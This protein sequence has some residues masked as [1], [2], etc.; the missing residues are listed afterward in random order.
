MSHRPSGGGMALFRDYRHFAGWRLPLALAMMLAGSLAEGFGIL[1]IVP[2]VALA[3]DGSQLPDQLQPLVS[4][5][6]GLTSDHR[7]LVAVA[8][9]VG[10]M[11]LRA[12]L[13]YRRDVLLARL[14]A[15][16]E[17]S[18]QVRAAAALA[19]RGWPFAAKIGQAGM[20]SLLLTDINRAALAVTM[21]QQ[22]AIALAMLLVQFALAYYLS[23]GMALVAGA[24]IVVGYAAS[25]RWVRKGDRSG[26]VLSA[27][28]DESTAA[29]FRI[30]AGL[31]AALAQGTVPQFLREYR[32]S[33]SRLVSTWAVIT[34][35]SS[36]LRALSGVASALAASLLLV[37]GVRLFELPLAVLLPLLVLFARMS[38]PALSL[39]HSVQTAAVAASAFGAVQQRI[40]ELP[41]D[42][43]IRPRERRPLDWRQ[44]EI[45]GAAFEYSAGT[46]L[47]HA[48]LSVGRGE[49]VGIGGG[50]GAGKTTLLD[51]VAGLIVPQTGHIRVDR[52]P[53]EGEMLERWRDQLAYVGQGDM[54]FD[55]SV[56]DNLLADGVAAD[57]AQLWAALETVGL[58]RRIRALAEGLDQRVGDRGSSLSGG[59]R[60][61]LTLARAL[62]RRPALLILD[63]ATSALD[64]D[65]E[66]DILDRIRAIDPR[67]A[68]LVVAHRRRTLACCDRQIKIVD[69]RLHGT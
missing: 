32:D 25:W 47:A 23:P 33:L 53:L 30:H 24:T 21:A 57:D 63:E 22:A 62:L 44:L 9:F 8:L 61:R 14:Q 19:E 43:P 58:A 27:A 31:K 4:L 39:Q 49:W 15:E 67:P 1:M 16:H 68:A 40:G 56:R 50:S 65:S 11:S 60:Q 20:Q 46:G 51:L 3:M 55:D 45:D 17:A 2:V 36:M 35:D 28:Y 42:L 64:P 10:A 5:T 29:G 54:V 12:L 52:Q 41:Q 6:A 34:S 38:A 48:S 18:M 59:E 66:A 37:V 69:G 7:F 26:T 13:L